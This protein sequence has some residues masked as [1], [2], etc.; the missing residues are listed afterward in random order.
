V[1]IFTH[2]LA[3]LVATKTIKIKDEEL[4]LLLEIT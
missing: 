1:W 4:D 3:C 2:G